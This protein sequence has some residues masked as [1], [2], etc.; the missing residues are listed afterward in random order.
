MG[1]VFIGKKEIYSYS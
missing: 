1:V